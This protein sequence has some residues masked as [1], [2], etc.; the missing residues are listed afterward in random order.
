MDNLTCSKTELNPDD[1]FPWD[2]KWYVIPSR[3][4]SKYHWICVTCGWV[5]YGYLP[6]VDCPYCK[7]EANGK[8]YPYSPWKQRI[9]RYP[10]T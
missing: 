4:S 3:M 7:G 9:N 1:A 8:P 5:A 6:P 2:S 10:H